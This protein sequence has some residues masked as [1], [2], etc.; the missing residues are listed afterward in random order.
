MI[1]K[2]TKQILG[3]RRGYWFTTKTGQHIYVD[4]DET[5]KQACGRVYKEKSEKQE[6]VV[7]PSDVDK[8]YGEEFKGYKGQAAIEKLLKEKRGHVKGA[9]HRDDMGDID[10]VWGS[11][12]AGL[13]HIIK[14]RSAERV[15]EQGKTAHIEEILSNIAE[16]IEGGICEG[17]NKRGNFEI[18]IDKEKCRYFSIVAPEYHNHKVTFVVTAFR[19]DK[20]KEH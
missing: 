7:T 6:K 8:L 20:K 2:T 4:E 13:Q 16:T 19:R 18:F 17:K 15:D 12:T 1:S 9:F 3:R 10:L 14:Q 11:D 5:P